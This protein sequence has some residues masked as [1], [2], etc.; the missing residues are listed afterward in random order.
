MRLLLFLLACQT[1][2]G[3]TYYVRKTGSDSNDGSSGTPW[4]TIG[5]ANT[6]MVAGDTVIIG[7]GDYDENIR[8]QTSGTAGNYI[9][10]Q[11]ENKW[12]VTLRSFRPNGDYIKCDGLKLTQFSNVGVTTGSPLYIDPTSDN[13]IITNIWISDNPVAMGEGFTFGAAS[14]AVFNSSMNFTNLGFK[15]GSAVYLGASGLDPY[16]FTNHNTAWTISRVEATTMWLTNGATM[17]DPDPGTNYWAAIAPG[18]TGVPGFPAI[19]FNTSGGVVPTN[20]I[21]VNCVI[22]NWFGKGMEHQGN[23]NQIL[24]NYFTRLY[25]FAVFQNFQGNNNVVRGNIAKDLPNILWYTGD[26]IGNITHPG[27]ADWYDYQQGE[28]SFFAQ[29]PPVR[30]NNVFEW[31]WF[32]NVEN[33]M[34]RIDDEEADTYGLILR[35]NVFVGISG[36]MSGGC[37]AMHWISNT[38]YK[39][40]FD[41][42]APLQIGG[43][44]PQQTNYLI[45]Q[46]LFADCGPGEQTDITGFY[47]Y[48][49]NALN[50]IFDSNFVS[51]AE[52]MGYVAKDDFSE[53]NGINGGDPGFVDPWNP[54]GADG[55][56]FTDDD[57]LKVLPNFASATLGGGALGIRTITNGYPVAHFRITSPS[58]WLEDTGTNYNAQWWTNMPFRRRQVVRPYTTPHLIGTVPVSA[59]FDAAHSISG[60]GGSI[61]NTAITDYIWSWGDGHVTTAS[62]PTASHTFTRVGDNPVV[63]TVMNSDGNSHS[64]TNW[65]RTYGGTNAFYVATNGNNANPGTLFLPVLTIQQ[66]VNLAT[67]AGASLIVGPGSYSETVA[68]VSNGT[69]AARITI[70]GQRGHIPP[71]NTGSWATNRAFNLRHHYTSLQNFQMTPNLITV[72]YCVQFPRGSHFNMVSN[73]LMDMA[74]FNNGIFAVSWESP[75]TKPFGSDAGSSNIVI[76]NIITRGIGQP[77]IGLKGYSNSVVGNQIISGASIDAAYVQGSNNVFS[78]NIF[79]NNYVTNGQGNHPDFIQTLGDT[80]FFNPTNAIGSDNIT[81]E[82]NWVDGVPAGGITQFETHLSQNVGN[83]LFINNVFQNISQTASCSVPGVRYFNNLFYRVGYSTG[84]ALTFGSRFYGLTET[85]SGDLV[86]GQYYGL[87][88]VNGDQILHDGITI[89]KGSTTYRTFRATA[90]TYTVV[91]GGSGTQ[92]VWYGEYSRAHNAYVGNNVFYICGNGST[93]F[94]WYSVEVDLPVDVSDGLDLPLT[95]VWAN[96]NAVIGTNYQALKQDSQARSIGDGAPDYWDP[97]R[98]WEDQGINGGNPN[99]VDEDARDWRPQSSSFL[100]T[101]G[102]NLSAIFTRDRLQ[103]TRQSEPQLWDMGPYLEPSEETTNPGALTFSST[104]FTAGENG[105][106]TIT[107]SRVG[108]SDGAVSVGYAT[109]NGTATAGSDYT[110]ASGTLNWVDGD[111]TDKTYTVS[112]TTDSSDEDNETVINTLSSPTGGASL[113]TSTATLTIVDD[114]DP[115]FKKRAKRKQ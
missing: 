18:G 58:S 102:T 10:Y 96:Y 48:T 106:A 19:K 89:T 16:W 103:A 69:S 63:L 66:G 2:F 37:D 99:F 85:A 56:P 113:G 33:Q 25:S 27:G 76:S 40:A 72:T 45:L 65:Y 50:P 35:N 104:T 6:T 82:G 109:S 23:N 97:T 22:S 61:T 111:A 46:N 68:T 64:I 59:S 62:I 93:N 87:T 8:E 1:A 29:S 3:A 70:D 84:A 83:Y 9:T 75:S 60:V 15:V 13:C 80:Q 98:W 44:P 28:F 88:G 41:S 101:G 110:A 78:W 5:K 114:D 43:R 57:G 91:P 95:N 34:G 105:S 26:E 17:M 11:A 42:S 115:A 77:M 90:T 55:V 14:N 30:T 94:G 54:M 73:N 49:T 20:N 81:V 7:D 24:S 71:P 12:G 47:G 38:F 86:P 51:S 74:Y 52:I 79:T 53:T 112:I 39:S 108:G 31:N 100:L 92:A 36:H 67:N 21:V 107:V 32:E 4:L